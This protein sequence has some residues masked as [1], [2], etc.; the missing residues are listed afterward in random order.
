MP[1][2]LPIVL[3]GSQGEG[4]GQI[5]RT[6]LSLSAITGK[7]FTIAK[8]RANRLKPGLRP[9]P[10]EAARAIASLVAA[11]APGADVGSSR[12]EFRPRRPPR[13]GELTFD[14]G[15][16]TEMYKMGMNAARAMCDKPSINRNGNTVTIDSACKIQE[17]KFCCHSAQ[18]MATNGTG[19]KTLSNIFPVSW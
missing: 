17:E 8:I 15:T 18:N 12:L 4:G 1:E 5:L 16:D 13:A 14:I 2:P 6:A 11:E 7:P 10:R 3:D 9:Q 19:M